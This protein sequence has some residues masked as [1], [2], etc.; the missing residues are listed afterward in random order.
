MPKLCLAPNPTPRPP[1]FALPDGATDC[2]IHLFPADDQYPYVADRDYTPAEADAAAL[3]SLYHTLGIKR[4]V[5][6][7]PSVYGHDN[8]AQLRRAAAVGLPF[9][10]VVVLEPGASDH[11]MQGLHDQ[12]ARAIR[13]ILAHPGGLDLAGLERSADQANAFGW[14][15]EFLVKSDQLVEL[16]PRLRGLSCPFSCDH[17]AFMKPALGLG[18]PGFATLRALLDTGR[19]WVK[20]S[21]AYRMTGQADQYAAVLPL[22]QALAESYG[23]RILWGSDWPHAGQFTAMPDTTHLLD[24]LAEWVPDEALRRQILVTN[25]AMFYGFDL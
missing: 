2:H 25:P 4:F 12:G 14:H 17:I 18:Q 16:A 19:G 9:R 23:E 24:V 13:Y 10:A 7:Q 21:G 22:A 3:R 6:V 8:R 15:L 11:E 5:A 20:F 1:N